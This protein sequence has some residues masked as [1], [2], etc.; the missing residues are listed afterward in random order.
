MTIDTFKKLAAILNEVTFDTKK[1]MVEIMMSWDENGRLD[2]VDEDQHFS[3]FTSGKWYYDEDITR[4]IARRAD[5]LECS[6]GCG[7]TIFVSRLCAE[8]VLDEAFE[9]GFAWSLECDAE[10]GELT[11]DQLDLI[12]DCG[13]ELEF[14]ARNREWN[15]EAETETETDLDATETETTK[16]DVMS[17]GLFTFAANNGKIT[18][19]YATA[20]ENRPAYC[21]FTISLRKAPQTPLYTIITNAYGEGRFVYDEQAGTY[22]QTRGTM[23]YSIPGTAHGVRKALKSELKDLL[24][25]KRDNT[26]DG[27]NDEEAQILNVLEGE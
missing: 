19:F 13:I 3:A 23:Q 16:G 1:D 14:A 6:D 11:N 15:D 5:Y 17:T 27:L 7:W 10:F 2:N 9:A 24:R 22:R 25:H 21:R 26:I 12:E 4:T 20:I 8:T 18:D